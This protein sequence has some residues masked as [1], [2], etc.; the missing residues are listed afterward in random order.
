MVWAMP[1][2]LA[3]TRGITIVLF[4]CRYLDVSVPCVCL[5]YGVICLQHTG[6]THSEISASMVICTYTELIAAYHV[7]LRL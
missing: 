3:T 5:P 1:R 7:L 2:S 4:S 6:L